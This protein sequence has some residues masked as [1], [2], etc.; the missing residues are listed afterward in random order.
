MGTLTSF[1]RHVAAQ[2]DTG[3]EPSWLATPGSRDI[4]S[5]VDLTSIERTARELGCTT[6]G[7]LD[8]TYFLLTLGMADVVEAD[9][10]SLADTRR[11]LALKTLLLPGGLGSTHK[12]MVFTKGI[13]PPVLRGLSGIRRLT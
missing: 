7:M 4:T 13:D 9:G 11:R 3:R 12:V 8:Q 1:R 10:T 2:P 5:H 6:L